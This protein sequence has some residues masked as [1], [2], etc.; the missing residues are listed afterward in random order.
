MDTTVEQRKVEEAINTMKVIL[1]QDVKGTGLKGEL[2]NVSDGYARNFLLPKKLAVEADN[3]AMNEYKSKEAAKKHH[4]EMEKQQA[5]EL[6]AT[7][8]DKTVK[9][10]AKAGKGGRLFGSVTSKEIAQAVGEQFG[11]QIDKKKIVLSGDIKA[12]GTYPFEL[13]V[14]AGISTKLQVM[15]TEEA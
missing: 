3:Q 6:A 2:K 1:L 10:T 12:F 13:K 4:L 8:Q 15:V 7:L 9:I 5:Q 14:Y 11:V